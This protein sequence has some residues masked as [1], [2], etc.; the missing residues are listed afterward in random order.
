MA[1]NQYLAV[2]DYEPTGADEILFDGEPIPHVAYT[3]SSSAAFGW[4]YSG[5][6]ATNV[7]RSILEHA[8]AV[9]DGENDVNPAEH[10]VEFRTQFVPSSNP[11]EDGWTIDFD[12]VLEFVKRN[13]SS[14]GG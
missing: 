1:S 9:A 14:N 5:A 10:Q 4:G 12:D 11:S 6:G 8:L 3:K 2:A 7:A 13:A